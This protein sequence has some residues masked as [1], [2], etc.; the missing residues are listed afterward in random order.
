MKITISAYEGHP[1][2][3]SFSCE[4]SDEVNL[5][6]FIEKLGGLVKC[7]FPFIEC[8]DVR[9]KGEGER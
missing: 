8:L 1:E 4:I 9:M 2:F 5:T 6:D 7:F 3:Q